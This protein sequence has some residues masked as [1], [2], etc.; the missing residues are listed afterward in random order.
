M[1]CWKEVAW[2]VHFSGKL[3]IV[4]IFGLLA[5][6]FIES[7]FYNIFFL[8]SFASLCVKTILCK[9]YINSS[10]NFVQNEKVWDFEMFSNKFV[11][12]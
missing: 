5:S 12:P 7:V 1:I 10:E 9:N 11:T 3:K 2:L 6:D 8:N 4:I